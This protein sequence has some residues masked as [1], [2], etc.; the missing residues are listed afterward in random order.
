M[1]DPKAAKMR[2]DL[3]SNVSRGTLLQMSRMLPHQHTS[4][5]AWDSSSEEEEDLPPPP[6]QEPLHTLDT[7]IQLRE[8]LQAATGGVEKKKKREIEIPV[9]TQGDPALFKMAYT[10]GYEAGLDKR[11]PEKPCATCAER[12]RKNRIAA[13]EQRKRQR[14]A[15]ENDS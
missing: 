12:R 7:L 10:L 5:K 13:A 11:D 14:E 15:E 6:T 2:L 4:L 1:C 8:T 9:T 3:N